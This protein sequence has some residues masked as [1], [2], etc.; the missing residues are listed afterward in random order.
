MLFRSLPAWLK[1]TASPS[2]LA[3][4]QVGQLTLRYK[5]PARKRFGAVTDQIKL[6]AK[7]GTRSQT[8]TLE[9]SALLEIAP[10][11]PA[12]PALAE[13]APK[14]SL[15]KAEHDFGKIMPT[16]TRTVTISLQNAGKSPLKIYGVQAESALVRH[17]LAASKLAPGASTRLY[18]HLDPAA[19]PGRQRHVV[20]LYTSDPARPQT[21]ITLLVEQMLLPGQVERPKE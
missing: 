10:N 16:K 8:I 20:T 12:T 15:S 21:P 5:G 14:L 4:G 1:A 2:T 11:P 7:R 3:P 6:L 9:V 18:L 13:A 19:D 17:E